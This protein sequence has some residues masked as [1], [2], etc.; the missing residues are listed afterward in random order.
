MATEQWRLV[1]TLEDEVD[2]DLEA[3]PLV[4]DAINPFARKARIVLDDPDGSKREEYPRYSLVD[5]EVRI[6]G[7]FDWSRRFSGFVADYTQDRNETELQVLTHDHWLKRKSVYA[8]YEDEAVSSILEDLIERFSPLEWNPDLV[9]IENDRVISREWSGEL[10]ENAIDELVTVS[11]GD[12]LFGATFDREFYF[13]PIETEDAPRSFDNPGEYHEVGWDEDGKRDANRAVVRYGEGETQGVVVEQSLSAQRE[14]AEAIGA[15]DERVEV[16]VPDRRPDITSEDRA[17]DWA[18]KLLDERSELRTGTIST[19][20][21]F[22][23]LP[24][25]VTTVTDPD[26]DVDGEFRVVETNY[27]WPAEQTEILVADKQIDTAD[28]L[29]VLS[30]DVQ[31]LELQDADPDAPILETIDEL[32]GATL[33]ATASITAREFGTQQFRPGFGG[34]ALGFD[35]ASPGFD[36]AAVHQASTEAGRVTRTALNAVRDGWRGEGTPTIHT[37]GLGSGTTPPS[38]NDEDL[39]EPITIHPATIS[40][41]GM[42][43]IRWSGTLRFDSPTELVEVGIIDAGFGLNGRV[44]TDGVT[45]PALAPVDVSF[46][47]DVVDN[48]DLRGVL[49][50]SG[51][52]TV[53]DILADNDPELP[54]DLGFGTDATPEAVTDNSLGNLIETAS[55]DWGDSRTLGIGKTEVVGRLTEAQADGQTIRELGQLTA[56]ETALTR[57]TFGQ[58]GFLKEDFEL[59]ANQRTRFENP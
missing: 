10:L 27:A 6:P 26:N 30:D 56:D 16:E 18:R 39:E 43:A 47:I 45:A 31:R 29:R 55:I 44:V 40:L 7:F 38:R 54:V 14:L 50:A 11:G 48:P 59:E 17:R 12:E 42:E 32:S 2:D 21:A 57:I 13:R 1:K 46:R 36:I 34:D 3:L 28:E 19:W 22:A 24:G 41:A 15:G 33:E 58:Q 53:R 4:R 51:G 37:L 23:V 52:A 25:Q 49:T 8:T 5:L 9:D 35:G 20:E